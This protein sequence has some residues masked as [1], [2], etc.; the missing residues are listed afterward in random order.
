[1]NMNRCLPLA[2]LAALLLFQPVRS[3]TASRTLD[4]YFIDVEGGA[5]TLIVTPAGESLLVDSGF[6][7]DRD[8]GRI[9]HVAV[10]VA[11]LKQIDHCVIT[12]WHRDHVGGIATLAKLI[13]VKNY[14]DH[15]LPQTIAADMQAEL[16]EA[17]KQTSQGK[18][19]ALKPG[20]EI[21]LRSP[22]YMPPLQVRVLAA[23][24]IVLGEKPGAPQIQPCGPDFQSI[25]EDI[26]DNP[27]SV[28]FLLI[29]GGF[30]FFDG[31]DLSWNIENRLVCPK[32][33]VGVIDVY[34]VDHHG[35]DVSNNPTLLRALNPRV[36][37]IDSGP[38]K[39]GEARTYA[40]L[41]SLKEIEAVYQLHR[42]LRTTD[43]DNTMS[44][45][46]A[47]EEEAC[48]GNFIKLSVD[49]KG[50]SYTVSIPAK[51]ISRTYRTR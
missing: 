31:G 45:Y 21:K 19:V 18:S 24:G 29:F 8:A 35:T 38:R 7:G 44:G 51:Q 26:T 27:N 6:P 39:G 9:A 23:N 17:Y 5:A 11:G 12:H 40:T 20:D 1:M 28:G 13:P 47:N 41:T 2:L 32:N 34:Q 30:K 36:A 43:K 15:G 10:E 22:K 49:P 37:V 16:V 50:K 4:I 14:Y 3:Q 42:N 25:P 46:I 33:L 48:Q